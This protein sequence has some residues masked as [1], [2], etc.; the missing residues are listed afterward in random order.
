[1]KNLIK[2]LACIMLVLTALTGVISCSADPEVKYVAFQVGKST[3]V[4]PRCNKVYDTAEKA[5]NCCGP[6]EVEKPVYTSVVPAGT[7]TVYHVQQKTTGGNAIA[8]YVLQD[9]EENKNV[10]EN[11]TV[12]TLKKTYTGF[13]AKTMSHNQSVIYVFYDR[14]TITYTFKTGTEGKLSDGTTERVLK[15]LYGAFVTVPIVSSSTHNYGGWFTS[16][17]QALP[18]VFGENDLEFNVKW[19]EKVAGGFNWYETPV[20]ISGGAA[21]A[22][23]EY[24]YFG[25]FPKT[26][27]SE[28]SGI[29][30]DETESK[31]IGGNTYYKGSNDGK[32]YAK[33]SAK[34]YESKYK[35][36]DNSKVVENEVRYF[37]VEP[38][39]WKVITTDYKGKVLLV[40]E[41]ILT[42][43]V[44]YCVSSGNRTIGGKTVCANNYKYSTIRA[45]LNGRYEADDTQSKTEYA[46]KGLLQTAFTKSAQSLIADTEVDNSLE[47]TG[48]TENEYICENTTDKL[49]LLSYSEV[50]NSAYFTNDDKRI[51]KTT[52]Y[53]KANYASQ[54]TSDGE[55][56]CWWLRS[57]HSDRNNFARN[58]YDSGFYYS[59]LVS[60]TNDGVVPALSI[61]F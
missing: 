10:T 42:G 7:Y 16:A 24:V 39:K 41:D 51:R 18:S 12:D 58:I 44:P 59:H 20:D 47:S 38:I 5:K 46:E 19:T 52:D 29:V 40:A 31:T 6:E 53:A 9:T 56:G 21:T 49:F 33:V 22:S 2:K 43:H 8:D 50:Y 1:M 26:V 37:L 13:T 32:W 3:Y 25:V 61:S 60:Y 45:Y 15:G 11:S 23:S 34:P 36:S 30:V 57:P 48:Y 17:N 35:Y 28:D 14:N 54:S 27:L 55:G 4:C